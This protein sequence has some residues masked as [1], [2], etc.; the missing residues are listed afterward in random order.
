VRLPGVQG[1]KARVG[2]EEVGDVPFRDRTDAGERLAGRLMAYEGRDVVVVALP[3]GGVPV[4]VPVAR[5]LHAPLDVLVV[6][7]LGVP[8]Q[9]ELGMGAIGEDGVSV[10]ND[11]MRRRL[12]ITDDQLERV[13]VRERL[14]VERRVTT[15]R[16]GRLR[17]PLGG[18]IVII[19][20]DGVATGYTVRAAAEIVRLEGASRVVIAVPVGAPDALTALGDVAD[21]VVAVETPSELSAIGEWY[22]DFRA[23]G[24]DEVVALLNEFI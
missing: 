17:V 15:Y 1:R 14:E 7:K 2:D 10:V 3:R 12:S 21:E 8:R 13:A 6:R 5:A 11:A 4:A 19:V 23:T 9:P 22:D 18:R 24:D 16:R 20:D